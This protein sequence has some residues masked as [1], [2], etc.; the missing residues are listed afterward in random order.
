MPQLLGAPKPQ[1]FDTSTGTFLTGG[2]LYS[3][4]VNSVTAKSTYPSN[5]D[6]LALTNANTNPITLNARGEPDNLIWYNGAIKFVLKDV[7]GNQ[8][9]SA[10]YVGQSG[11]DILDG[12]GNE[13]I[14]FVTTN[15]AVNEITITNAVTGQAPIIS[16]SGGDTDVGLKITAKGD[17]NLYLDGG[18][19]G[20]VEINS[21]ASG[22]INL[23]RATNITGATSITGATTITGSATISG[24]TYSHGIRLLPAPIGL[25]FPYA[26]SIAPPGCLS[27]DGT[28]ISRTTY[29]DLFAICG[30]T[31]GVGDGSTTFNLPDLRRRTI[32]GLGGSATGPVANTRGATGGEELHT[33]TEAEMFAHTHS[34][35][36]TSAASGGSVTVIDGGPGASATGSTGSTTPFNVMQ[37][38]M[39]LMYCIVASYTVAPTASAIAPSTGVAAGGTSCTV[40]GTNFMPGATTVTIGGN[41]VTAGSVTVAS[42]TSLTFSTPP[43]AV[44]L[45]DVTITNTFGTSSAIAGGFTYT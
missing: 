15:N 33:M 11:T 2:F 10:D 28:A 1:F 12:N 27:L 30:T 32:I 37:P 34:L 6:A 4:S 39:T 5:A 23:R 44:G 13:L 42:S 40:T 36:T 41:V 18:S 22:N 17:G 43:H 45:V 9:W 38:S 3:Y 25:I 7:S 26:G 16:S 31:F 8:L 20:D 35:H 21:I 29:A 24:D 14:I 19:T